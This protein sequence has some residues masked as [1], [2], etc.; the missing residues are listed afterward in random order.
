MLPNVSASKQLLPSRKQNGGFELCKFIKLFPS[1]FKTT[2]SKRDEKYT[3]G[4]IKCCGNPL[5]KILNLKL[6]TLYCF[7]HIQLLYEYFL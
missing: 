5:G 1:F 6:L 2:E 3:A 7:Y 4:I